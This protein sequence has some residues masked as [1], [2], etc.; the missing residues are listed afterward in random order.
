MANGKVF[1]SQKELVK[2]WKCFEKKTAKAA[3]KCRVCDCTENNPCID[4]NGGTC[5]WV[6]GD[7]LCS[8]CVE[9]ARKKPAR[10]T[11]RGLSALIPDKDEK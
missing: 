5:S 3:R 2:R 9:V 11:G 7:D 1:I 4:N 10:K 8:A 6:K